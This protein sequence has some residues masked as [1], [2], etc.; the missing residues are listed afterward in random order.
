MCKEHTKTKL[1]TAVYFLQVILVMFEYFYRYLSEKQ[2][3]IFST[4][5]L[6]LTLF[7]L[8]WNMFHVCVV[9]GK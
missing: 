8:V 4:M 2:L 1:D 9:F 7:L 5:A 6:K 3:F